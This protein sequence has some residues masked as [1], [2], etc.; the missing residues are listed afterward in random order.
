N[1]DP[2][3]MNNMPVW[4]RFL[5]VF[6][7][8]FMNFLLAFVLSVALIATNQMPNVY[9]VETLPMVSGVMEGMPAAQAGFEQWDI[10]DALDGDK[11]ALNDEGTEKLRSYLNGLPE[12]QSV[13][14]TLRRIPDL[15]Q[16]YTE[17]ALNRLTPEELSALA[18]QSV[19]V[20]LVPQKSEGR[21]LLGVN[22]PSYYGRY[23]CN[24]LGAVGESFKFMY[25]TA[26]ETYRA[27]IG[28]IG[29]LFTGGR[30]E[31]GTV[32]GVVGI[33]SNVSTSLRASFS[34]ALSLGLLR[35]MLFIM[36]IS[37]SL[38]IMNLLP[39]PALDGG[40]L[41]LLI[42][43]WITGKHVNRKVEAYINLAGLALLLGIMLVV[44]YFDIRTIVRN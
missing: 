21:V 35:M 13:Q 5:T 30:I 10:I 25:H 1:S 15:K 9:E 24:V 34:D 26:V 40:R 4:K 33:V 29:N 37:L 17:E 14:V 19:T 3:A 44:T 8:P 39:L 18:T 31:E 36:V 32:S 28:L 22:L 23:D 7:G 11:I 6:A 12:G 20:T 38:G 43:E 2:R 27:L 42:F 41:I 16:N